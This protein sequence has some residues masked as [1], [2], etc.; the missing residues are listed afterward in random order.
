MSMAPLG[1]LAALLGACAS[2]DASHDTA[3]AQPYRARSSVAVLPR[4]DTI[5]TYPCTRCHDARPAD[6][7]ERT[8]S[9]L[10]ERITLRHGPA[11]G[12]CYRC[13]DASAPDRLRLPTG[14]PVAFDRSFELCGYCHGEKLADWNAGIHGLTTG[15][16]DGNKERRACTACHDPHEPAFPKMTPRCPP[17]ESASEPHG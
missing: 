6:P 15:R 10:H 14:E 1:L 12:W 4:T 8:L 17:G 3:R 11:A 5:P 7:R 16:W 13:H 2:P 9:E